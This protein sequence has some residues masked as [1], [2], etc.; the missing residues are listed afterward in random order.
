M[1]TKISLISKE[2]DWKEEFKTVSI[3]Y[4]DDLPNPLAL[5]AKLSLWE[6]YC[7]TFKGL[8]PSNITSTLKA[9]SLMV[10][11]MLKFYFKF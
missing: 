9:V 5:D 11:R 8:C 3:F 4:Y 1:P 6:M 10:L 2:A 7:M